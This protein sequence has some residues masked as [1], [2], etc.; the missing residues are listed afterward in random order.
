MG[1]KSV[2]SIIENA[3]K[4]S[5]LVLPEDRDTIRKMAGD[6]ESML[7]ALCELRDEG[8]AATPQAQSLGRN[9]NNKV[10]ELSNIV[11]RAIQN[12]ER[13]GGPGP[14]HTVSGKFD[15]ASKWLSNLDL[16][17]KG[18]GLQATKAIIQDGRKIAQSCAPAQREDIINLCNDV[19]ELQR[20]L[21][22]LCRRGMGN[23]PMAKELARKLNQKLQ[24]LKRLIERGLI[25]RVVEDFID[26]YTPLKQFTE[27][28]HLPEEVPN[29]EMTFQEK[30]NNLSTFSYKVTKT[31]R[32]VATGLATN[33]RLAE[34][35]MNF[36]NQVESLT[37]QLVSAGRIR[38]SHPDN[39]SA[40]E[41]FE[42]LRSQYQNNLEK[43][44]SM[45]DEAVDSVSFVNASGLEFGCLGFL[46]NYLLN[47]GCNLEVHQS[48]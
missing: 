24:E 35:L 48:V 29:R 3:R 32:N 14:A 45:I 23:S 39:K 27:A 41:H 19:E 4:V 46:A 40:D 12:I 37:P 2:R 8:N 5:E 11:N 36:S 15:Q 34:G 44:Q 42:N 10:K 22:D 20:Q 17:D 33:K 13:T 25:T 16:D 47:R 30:S 26:I 43:L 18:V 28:V 7:N 38:F 31:A 9:I 21:E 1:E 6:I